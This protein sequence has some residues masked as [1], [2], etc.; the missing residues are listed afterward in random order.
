MFK[1]FSRFSLVYQLAIMVLAITAVVFAGLTVYVS[2]KTSKD[3]IQAV[4]HELEREV[5]LIAGNFEFFHES[6]VTRTNQLGEIFFSMFPSKMSIDENSTTPVGQYNAPLLMHDGSVINGNFSKPDEFTR[7]TGGNATIFMRYG[8]DFL[9]VSTSLRKANNDRAFGTLLGTKHPGYKTL[10]SGNTYEGPAFLFGRNY[11]TKYI[12][13]K[14]SAGKVIGILYVGFNYSSQ[15]KALKE[16]VSKIKFGE[17]GYVY[18]ISAKEG[19][20][21][22][23]LVMH[24]SLE[25]KNLV[26]MT[27]ATGN[28]VFHKLL[29]ADSGVLHY[30]WKNASGSVKDKLV[31]FK[32]VK[33]WNWV[34]AAGSYTE[35]F[36]RE[37]VSLRN[38]MIV[39]SVI[40]ALLIVGLVFLTLRQWL[41]PLGLIAKAIEALGSG[42]LR[43][44]VDISGSE[45]MDNNSNEIQLLTGHL[46]KM[47]EELRGL[48]TGILG[49]VELMASSSNRVAD[50]SMKTSQGVDRQLGDVDMVATAINEM[51]ATVQ[52][53]ASSAVSTDEAAKE[54]NDY[55]SE[56]SS[57]VN[58]VAS[59]I[60]ELA[61]E[62]EQSATVIE[63]VERESESIDTVLEVIR[64]IAEQTNLLALNAAIEAARAGEQGRGFAVVADEVRTL[65][66]RTQ[67]ST[68]EIQQIIER[69]Q[70]STKEAV[71]KM[72]FGREKAQLSVD[73]VTKAGEVLNSIT[74]S[75]GKISDMT[76]QIATATEEQSHVA[77]DVNRSVVNIR[78]ISSETANG[79]NEMI[80]ATS[81]MQHATEQLQQATTRFIV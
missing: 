79:A 71:Q 36:T 23:R 64:G 81:K 43:A 6:L 66:S 1:S 44:R 78:D 73:E 70:S 27:D 80:D 46:N 11:M 30:D 59:S 13:F 49:S 20:T 50:V 60:R 7:M 39:M 41:N 19:K 28:K 34:M 2:T 14:N 74:D 61:A 42:D 15:L 18:A 47:V 55:A 12:P 22:G 40:S 65:A 68:Q 16:K 24:P 76:A 29:E 54:S 48:I 21:K 17:T 63:K 33:G 56:G 35:E 25:G 62:V 52:E 75:I 53:V 5:G 8:D 32:H 69:L 26:E 45:D 72:Q 37:S 67:D 77:E 4:E 9:R 58:R 57:V 51:A 31:S 3:A 38:N 10:I